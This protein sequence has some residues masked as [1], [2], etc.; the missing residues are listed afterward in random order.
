[1][2]K[3]ETILMVIRKQKATKPSTFLLYKLNN[4]HNHAKYVHQYT[5]LTKRVQP[6]TQ[7]PRNTSS[8]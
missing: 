7:R 2:L 3:L 5:I 6:P 8:P 1:M 4:H